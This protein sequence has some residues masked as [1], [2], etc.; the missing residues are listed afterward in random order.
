M[1]GK[2]TTVIKMS[3]SVLLLECALMAALVITQMEAI[4]AGKPGELCFF[5]DQILFCLLSYLAVHRAGLEFIVTQI[6]TNVPIRQCVFMEAARIPM[7][8]TL[9][10][11]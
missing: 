2:A 7:V 6:S 5:T 4:Y 1:D 8:P 10:N 11:V 3:T 9:V